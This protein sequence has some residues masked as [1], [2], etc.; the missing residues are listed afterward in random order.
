MNTFDKIIQRLQ[1]CRLL[2]YRQDGNTITVDPRSTEGFSVSFTVTANEFMVSFDGWHVHFTSEA[3]ALKCF[4]LGLGS[5]P[6]QGF[7]QREDRL[8]LDA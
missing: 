2:S 7:P 8:P 5:V 1:S 6:S 3:E 4:T